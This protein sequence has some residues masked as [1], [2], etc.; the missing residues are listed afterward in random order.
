MT[1]SLM[2]LGFAQSVEL[3][4]KPSDVFSLVT[5]LT[6]RIDRYTSSYPGFV[7]ASVVVGEQMDEV[8]MQVTWASSEQGHMALTSPRLGEPDLF[9]I[10]FQFRARSMKFRTFIV[11]ADMRIP[12]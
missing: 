9:Q 1:D 5:V 11:A 10:A 2:S 12:W 8:H 3:V 6:A 7:G 4:V